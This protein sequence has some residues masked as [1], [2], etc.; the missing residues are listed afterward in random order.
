MGWVSLRYMLPKLLCVGLKP[1]MSK[2]Q[3]VVA[4][5]VGQILRCP[6]G[7]I[8]VE[9]RP[10]AI[11]VLIGQTKQ[12]PELTDE[13]IVKVVGHFK[14]FQGRKS[15]MAITFRICASYNELTCHMLEVMYTPLKLKQIQM[16]DLEKSGISH[17]A[18][19]ALPNSIIAPLMDRGST[20]GGFTP[21]QQR[22]HAIIANSS[23][24]MGI[25]KDDI[26]RQC[27][28]I[29]NKREIESILQMMTSEGHIFST[30]DD[31]TFKSTDA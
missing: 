20:A 28:G 18:E 6:G 17:Q 27:Q 8:T 25:H 26:V 15:L 31:D 22:V 4:M 11:I 3:N 19:G 24:E 9:N 21:N 5:T 16:K 29:I 1:G 14:E 13:A 30:V 12:E 2:A 7:E 23:D 10:V